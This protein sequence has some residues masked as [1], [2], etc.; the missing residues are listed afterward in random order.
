MLDGRDDGETLRQ[1]ARLRGLLLARSGSDKGSIDRISAAIKV[2]WSSVDQWARRSG[3]DR[4]A[5]LAYV[6]SSA[7]LVLTVHDEG[8]WLSSVGDLANGPASAVLAD[9]RF[10]EISRDHDNRCLRL[11]KRLE[12]VP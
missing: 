6:L 12:T 7:K 8:G 11:V 10:D 3:H 9:A 1:L 5:T 4:V 2:I